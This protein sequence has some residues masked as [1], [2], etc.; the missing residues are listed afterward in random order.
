[1]FAALRA[2]ATIKSLAVLF[3]LWS[4][5]NSHASRPSSAGT[6]HPSASQDFS[7]SG[8]ITRGPR[9]KSQIAITFDGGAEAECFDDLIVA[10]ANANVHSTFFITGQFV[11]NHPDCA[12]AITKHG[13]EVGNHTWSHLALTKESDVV[14]RDELARAEQRIVEVSGQ[15]PKPLWRAPYGDRDARVLKVA[16][17]LG[18]RSIYWTIDSLD[19]VE[20][21]K[22]PS[23][24]IDRITGKPDPEL[25]GA[26]ILMHVGERST[27]EA[28]PAIIANLQGRGFQLVTIS[29]LL[30][31]PR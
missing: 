29:K 24:L 20:P 4:C 13:H 16:S 12:A 31:S 8:E 5:S 25:D 1:L 14:I 10:L 6:S 9:G 27:A 19:G 11:N 21:K 30:E 15:N 2:A 22:T 3:L 17:S 18:Y 28:L 26:I 7:P 23:F